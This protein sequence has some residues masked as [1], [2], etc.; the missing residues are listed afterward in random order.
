M[1]ERVENLILDH[2]RHLRGGTDRMAAELHDMKVRLTA[3]E[4]GLAGIHRRMDRMD[5][6]LDRIERRLELTVA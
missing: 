6:H 3:V 5:G 2:L 1:N 4:E